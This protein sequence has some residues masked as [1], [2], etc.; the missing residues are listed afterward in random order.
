MTNIRSRIAGV[1]S[2]LPERKISNHE[3]SQTVDTTHEWIVER[4]GIE[5]RHFAAPDQKTSDLG[6]AAAREAL[7]NA[8]VDPLDVDLIVVA[9][10]TPED[11][12]FPS[13][14]VSVQAKLGCK[15]ALAFDVSAVC[16]GYLVAL[17]TADNFIRTGQ[18]KVAL[19]IGAEKLSDVLD[20]DDRRTCV[21]FGDGAGAVVLRAEETDE[22]IGIMGIYLHSD[23]NYRDI[24]HLTGKSDEGKK[25]CVI[26][27]E[28]RE[29][30]RHAV[31]KLTDSAIKTL[32]KHKISCEDID[33]FIPHQA[34][35][36]IIN[37]IAQKLNLPD[38]KIIVTV[39]QHA[40]TS[41]ASIPLALSDALKKGRVKRGDLILH[42]AIGAGLVWGSALVRF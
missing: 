12:T 17:S 14:A 13:T 21:L 19:V 35:V 2:Y 24:L 9:T 4:T 28:G 1:G 7:Q 37:A 41:A 38:E 20:M 31:S 6:S 3:L 23:G 29:V 34:N 32:A 10:S 16:S 25:P 11:N 40:N 26:S 18:A 42:E 39:D 5:F 22:D 8:G 30:F 27:M 15:N 33:W 36:R